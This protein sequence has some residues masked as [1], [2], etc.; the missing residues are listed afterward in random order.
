MWDSIY[1]SIKVNYGF[2]RHDPGHTVP[3]EWF[4]RVMV[5]YDIWF[6]S[7]GN[8]L[9]IEPGGTEHE[10]QRGS[11]VFFRPGSLFS[12]HQPEGAQRLTL[13]YFHFD[14]RDDAEAI[15][16]SV[17]FAAI[18][19]VLQCNAPDFCEAI[20]QRIH[21]LINP[22]PTEP[23]ATELAA[24]RHAGLLL[25]TLLADAFHQHTSPIESDPNLLSGL[26]YRQMLWIMGE[27]RR[28]PNRFRYAADVAATLHISADYANRLFTRVH[29]RSLQE[30]LIAARIEKAK[31]FLAGSD[32]TIT[33]IAEELGYRN[34]YFFSRQFKQLVGETPS[35]FRRRRSEKLPV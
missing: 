5:D 15:V 12:L 14:I 7:E 10:L 22:W 16:P 11:V 24:H 23:D 32:L 4:E 13:S 27:I 1:F 21:Q 9:L 17:Y 18:P 33:G 3:L 28:N 30:T 6:I 29:R 26:R 20:C 35:A 8:A 25:K 31:L 34:T 19:P 2:M